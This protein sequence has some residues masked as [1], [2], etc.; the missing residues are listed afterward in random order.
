VTGLEEVSLVARIATQ[1]MQLRQRESVRAPLP[2]GTR[3]RPLPHYSFSGRC[4]PVQHIDAR[5]TG[6]RGRSYRRLLTLPITV[7]RQLAQ[8]VGALRA[9]TS[10]WT[11]RLHYA[12]TQAMR[13][14][15]GMTAGL[16][17]PYKI[18]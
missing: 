1:R 10:G 15:P 18:P 7:Y 8:Y 11:I 2:W 6:Y 12:P 9:R 5:V 16:S 14:I 3:T 13:D 17:A 4:P